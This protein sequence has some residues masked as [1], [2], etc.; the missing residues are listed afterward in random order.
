M[1]KL[2]LAAGFAAVALFPL[3]ASAQQ[4]CEQQRDNRV[5]GTIAGAGVGAL[6][7]GA[8]AGRDDR[9][10]GVIIGGV[11]G[12]VVGNQLTRPNAD[13]AHAYG[14]YDRNGMWHATAVRRAD[15][16]GYY[17]RDGVWVDGAPNGYY[18]SRGQ[19]IASTDT[20]SASGYYD[21]NDRWVPASASGYYDTDG[22]WISGT[23]SGYYDGAGRWV[24]GPAVGHY[25][26]NGRWIS[27][28]PSGHRDA[29]GV[30][31]ADAQ[32][33]YYD[34]NGHWRAGPVVGYYDTEGRWIAAA[35]SATTH[36][37]NVVYQNQDR[38]AG[39]QMDTRARENWIDQ[40]IRA[41]MNN[42]TLSH[43]DGR[44]AL[45]T[46]YSIRRQDMNMRRDGQMSGRGQAYI[47]SR[48]DDLSHRLRFDEVRAG[49]N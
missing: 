6:I 1:N 22:Q 12:A 5:V 20:Q 41:G 33:G 43:R 14:Y 24:A 40:R 30:W 4:S 36:G 31:V 18:D 45:R 19:W 11:G 9:T 38:R 26:V 16:A 13:C 21:R 17:N 15:A 10:A 42:A 32:P 39:A 27:G 23:A 49:L 47:Q 28:A 8:I 7:G 34:S 3:V 35:A 2:S 44:Q 46:L 29:N 25:D 48:L 37:V